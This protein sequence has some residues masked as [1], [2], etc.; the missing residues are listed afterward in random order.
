MS[1]DKDASEQEQPQEPT[2]AALAD[3]GEAGGTTSDEDEPPSKVTKTMALNAIRRSVRDK[4]ATD[5]A[6]DRPPHRVNLSK[7]KRLG[8]LRH[9][10][11][12]DL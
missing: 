12:F 8:Q 9:V 3:S 7:S 6:K 5:K 11:Q 4:K 10:S 2:A 1:E